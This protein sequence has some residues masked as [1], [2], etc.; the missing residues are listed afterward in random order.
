MHANKCFYFYFLADLTP[1]LVYIASYPPASTY[2][3]DW[4][5][6]FYCS[7]KF[8]CSYQCSVQPSSS[9]EHYVPC[10]NGYFLASNLQNG[11][12]YAMSV[13]AIDGVGNLGTPSRYTWTVGRYLLKMKGNPFYAMQFTCM[14]QFSYTLNDI[15]LQ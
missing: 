14:L 1:P 3:T 10:N 11:Q 12:T 6:A 7:N 4:P 2:R 9:P 5:F 15:W 8:S 13:F